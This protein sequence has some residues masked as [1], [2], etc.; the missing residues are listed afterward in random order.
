MT[1]IFRAS[2]LEDLEQLSR[3]LAE[4]FDT[5]PETGSLGR[6][7]M[8]W[9][10]WDHRSDWTEPRSYV[11]EKSGRIIAHAGIWPVV[12]R[13]GRTEI[14]GVQ[15]IDWAAAADSPGAGLALLQKLAGLFDFI[16]SI[17]GSDVTRR[18]LP[19]FGFVEVA[20]SWIAAR[21]LRPFRQVLNH[22]TANWKLAPRLV[23]NWLWSMSPRPR[24]TAEW[25]AKDLEPG[26]LSYALIPDSP[27]EARF[28]P[29][30]QG[31][32]EY[33]LRCPA[34]S[35]RLCGF[36]NEDG[37]QGYFALGLSR[38]QA[39]IAGVW[40]RVACGEHWRAA[41]A[42]AQQRALDW[43]GALEIAAGGSIGLS[44]EAAAQTGF[45]IL[46]TVPVF[47]LAHKNGFELAKD[48]QFQ[49]IDDDASFL[50]L[51]RPSYLT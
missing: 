3:L 43:E 50:D 5:Q 19:S 46:R 51:G 25:C 18:I 29:R 27:A 17:G 49:M 15:M 39:R 11:I 40:L 9:K 45:R 48:F 28:S 22:Q 36:D 30:S 24:T 31:F 32:F 13:R 10:Y 44:A 34:V 35:F 23:R 14:R 1:G 38:G 41:F 12:F 47:F 2:T 20:Q 26:Q 8:A 33:L 37:P 6:E 4:A 16:Y 7:M 42:L 21:P